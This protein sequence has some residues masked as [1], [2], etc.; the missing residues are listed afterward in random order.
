MFISCLGPASVQRGGKKVVKEGDNVEVF[1]NVTGIPAPIVSWTNI[2]SNDDV[3]EGNLL[4]ISSIS[5]GQ[6]GKYKCTASNS[7]GNSST[8]VDIDVQCKGE[9]FL[10]CAV[11]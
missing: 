8:T 10:Y 11:I 2:E 7:C 5:R 9:L 3:I 1:C 6:A 4:N